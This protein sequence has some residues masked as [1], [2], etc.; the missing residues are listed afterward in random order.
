M[1]NHFRPVCLILALTLIVTASLFSQT[2]YDLPSGK[3]LTVINQLP[4]T[5]SPYF[6]EAALADRLGGIEPAFD[7]RV[8]ASIS[9]NQLQFVLMIPDFSP[10][11]PLVDIFQRPFHPD[12][13]RL[14][15]V[16]IPERYMTSLQ[17]WY[18]NARQEMPEDLMRAVFDYRVGY[19]T[20][21]QKDDHWLMFSGAA[22]RQAR[23]LP[24]VTQPIISNDPRYGEVQ[25]WA[26]PSGYFSSFRSAISNGYYPLNRPIDRVTGEKN[27]SWLVYDFFGMAAE[28]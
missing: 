16:G 1:K 6:D 11:E 23:G 20:I 15:P 18:V 24:Q 2:T 14:L 10:E 9:N 5:L 28:E 22:S 7:C 3:T 13:R 21:F 26:D 8:G 4:E 17:R 19:F 25:I 12:N 27:A